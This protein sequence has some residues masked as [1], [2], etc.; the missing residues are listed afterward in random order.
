M[1]YS[2]NFTKTLYGMKAPVFMR[3]AMELYDPHAF[4][5]RLPHPPTNPTKVPKDVAWWER[6]HGGYKNTVSQV[7]PE[8][9]PIKQVMRILRSSR[10][11]R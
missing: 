8:V 11:P 9:D 4:G 2:Q 7:R 10:R 5:I 1:D 6:T 3:D